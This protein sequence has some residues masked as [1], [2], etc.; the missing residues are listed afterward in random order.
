[1]YS[2]WFCD[3]EKAIKAIN[4]KLPHLK[5]FCEIIGNANGDFVI[6]NETDTWIIKHTDFSVWHLDRTLEHWGE[7][8]EVK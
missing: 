2:V 6:R 7:W 4:E 5:L 8:I 1:M 3:L